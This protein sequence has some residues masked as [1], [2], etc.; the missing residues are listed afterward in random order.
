MTHPT[1]ELSV[2]ENSAGLVLTPC[3]GTKDLPL[4]ESIEQLKS[5]GVTVVVTALSHE[6]M[7]EKGVGDLPKVVEQ[8]GLQWFH[9]PIED[10]CAPGH[11][12]QTHWQSI[13]PSLHQALVNGDKIAMHCMGGSGRTGLLAAHL[14]LEK[15]WE[16]QNIITHVQSLRPGAFTKDVQ[17]EYIKQFVN[18]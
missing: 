15:G 7:Q 14:L 16:L 17:V 3:P 18:Q 8:A 10:D 4:V 5:Q 11:Q 1:W 6:E 13:S 9:A 12:F 2:A